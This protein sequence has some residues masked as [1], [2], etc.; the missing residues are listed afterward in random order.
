MYQFWIVLQK[1]LE[2]ANPIIDDMFF[3][4]SLARGVQQP[5]ILPIASAS[6][7]HQGS[8][9][10][11]NNC[12]TDATLPAKSQALKTSAKNR[13]LTKPSHSLD[14]NPSRQVVYR[15][16]TKDVTCLSLSI[17][18]CL[19]VCLSIYLFNLNLESNTELGQLTMFITHLITRNNSNKVPPRSPACNDH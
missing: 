15:Y 19:S 18:I 13:S 2:S 4:S 1:I 6:T 12:T 7:S 10:S 9:N 17:I 8:S 5:R 11:T 16:E 14:V 3:S